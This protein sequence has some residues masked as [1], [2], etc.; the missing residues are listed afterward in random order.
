M[1]KRIKGF[2]CYLEEVMQ[3][4]TI[5]IIC[6]SGSL[7]KYIRKESP[8]LPSRIGDGMEIVYVGLGTKDHETHNIILKQKTLI[9]IPPD[10]NPFT[11]VNLSNYFNSCT[12]TVHHVPKWVVY[13]RHN[14]SNSI[15]SWHK[16]IYI[17]NN[18]KT[19]KHICCIYL[20]RLG[21]FSFRVSFV[22]FSYSD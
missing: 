1:K 19:E 18:N 14:K 6:Y 20:Y 5:S 21:C 17:L 2:P 4:T 11:A 22:I 9:P 15:V 3:N 10:I 13:Q 8:R 7:E 12:L 16:D